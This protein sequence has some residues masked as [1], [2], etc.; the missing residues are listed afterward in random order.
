M[1][2]IAIKPQGKAL[3]PDTM[4]KAMFENNHDGAGFMYAKDGQVH[5]SK[6][7][8]T[9]PLL[10]S[11]LTALG[12]VSE[13]PLILHCRIGTHGDKSQANTHPYPVSSLVDDLENLRIDCQLGVVHNGVI[14]GLIPRAKINDTMEYILDVIA[15][16]QTLN[17]RAYLDSMGQLILSTT[18]KSKLAF[19]DGTGEIVTIGDFVD[20]D[21]YRFSNA[22]YIE[23][24]PVVVGSNY[25]AYAGY[26]QYEDD[27]DY[28]TY[29]A[30]TTLWGSGTWVSP[31]PKGSFV[32]LEE[33]KD[34]VME[35]LVPDNLVINYAGTVFFTKGDKITG[36]AR[37]YIGK[38]IFDETGVAVEYN[39]KTSK[40]M[41]YKKGV[42][43]ES[44]S[45]VL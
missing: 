4:I 33:T 44:L 15:P 13:Y 24:A 36:R 6:G 14:S 28:P 38:T 17:P 22:S 37:K 45:V 31:V 20:F 39:T 16:L 18:C 25:L 43:N 12:D 32:I 40:Y 21:G 23:R 42:K 9:L 7:Y 11:A 29:H 35:E 34:L 30:Q 8:M 5:I 1:C 19:L 2:I 26:K 10:Q 41:D 3:F 27:D